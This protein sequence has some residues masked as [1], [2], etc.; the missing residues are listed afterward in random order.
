MFAHACSSC[1][2]RQLIFVNQVTSLVNTDH[3]IEVGFTPI[4]DGGGPLTIQALQDGDI[5]LAIVYTADPTISQNDLV[6]LEDAGPQTVANWVTAI[7][8]GPADESGQTLTF[9]VTGNTNSALFAVQPAVA[10]DGTLWLAGF[11]E[12][13]HP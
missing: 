6:V 12:E 2:K 7:S 11:S 1:G 13:P 5:Q 8:P 10:A 3:G 4:E 9:N